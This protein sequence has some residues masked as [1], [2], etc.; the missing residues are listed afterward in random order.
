[1]FRN[2]ETV[3]YLFLVMVICKFSYSGLACCGFVGFSFFLPYWWIKMYILFIIGLMRAK[4]WPKC[5]SWVRCAVEHR[6]I[7]AAEYVRSLTAFYTFYTSKI[8]L[9][10]RD[11]WLRHWQTCAHR[12]CLITKLL[13]GPAT[14]RL[15]IYPTPSIATPTIAR[16]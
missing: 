15:I 1:M 8:N 7:P 12:W 3:F 10:H 5:G 6:T 13:L 11:G 14:A 16:I 4:N 9:G 2:K